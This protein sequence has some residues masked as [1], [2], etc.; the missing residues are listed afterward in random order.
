MDD[1][2]VELDAERQ[3]GRILGHPAIQGLPMLLEVP[4][5]EGNGPDVEN[6]ER[7]RR[8]HREGLDARGG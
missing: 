3:R 2:V 6:M 8:L 1:L 4:G 7:V 5:A